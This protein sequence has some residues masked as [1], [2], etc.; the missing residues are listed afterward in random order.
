MNEKELD[1]Y[2][3]TECFKPRRIVNKY[4]HETMYVRC[5]TCPACMA[6]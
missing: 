2:L 4:T 5:G 3:A 1:K 6:H